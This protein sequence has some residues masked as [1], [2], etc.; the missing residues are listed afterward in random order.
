MILK[1]FQFIQNASACVLTTTIVKDPISHVLTS[2]NWL[3]I[4]SKI[5]FKTLVLIY[6]AIHG[7]GPI[8]LKQL[9]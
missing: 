4:K 9:K 5:E 2:L 7:Q 8:Y 3:L 1:T 6:K